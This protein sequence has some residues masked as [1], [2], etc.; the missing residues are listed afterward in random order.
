MGIASL[1]MVACDY[2]SSR[3]KIDYP[4]EQS[5]AF[6]VYASHCSDCHAP[7]LPSAHPANEWP[8]VIERMQ[9]HLLER[10][11]APIHAADRNVLQDYLVSHAVGG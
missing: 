1:F 5:Q 6:N 11:M 2:S 7:P 8:G 9:L 4:D 3:P 10:S